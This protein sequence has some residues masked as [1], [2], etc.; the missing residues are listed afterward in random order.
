MM[1][2]LVSLFRHVVVLAYDLSIFLVLVYD[3]SK[4]KMDCQTVGV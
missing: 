2:W 4:R 3:L 1:C